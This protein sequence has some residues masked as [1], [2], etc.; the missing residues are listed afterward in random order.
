MKT[1]FFLMIVCLTGLLICTTAPSLEAR[2]HH[3]PRVQLNIGTECTAKGDSYVVRRFAVPQRIYIPE[4]VYI[5]ERVY[6]PP[7]PVVYR[8][9]YVR[10]EPRVYV[11]EEIHVPVRKVLPS[12]FAGLSFTWNIR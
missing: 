6:V 7:R 2:H 4:E 1:K 12:L 9:V 3:G 8:P 10:P 11:A 5:P